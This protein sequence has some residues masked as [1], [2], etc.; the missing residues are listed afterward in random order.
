MQ[1]T[2]RVTQLESQTTQSYNDHASGRGRSEAADPYLVLA[3]NS[4]QPLS[5]SCRVSIGDVHEVVLERGSE[6]SLRYEVESQHR[7]LVITLPDTWMSGTHARLVRGHGWWVLE[8][9]CSKNGTRI[10]GGEV[11]RM[12]LSDGDLIEVGGTFLLFYGTTPRLVSEPAV[13]DTQELDDLPP[14]LATLNLPL[15]RQLA[16]LQR[17]AIANVP[18]VIVGESGTGKEVTAR[19]VHELSGRTG[20]L[21]AINCGAIPEQ[22]VES[23]LFGHRKGAFSGAIEDR[24]GLIRSAAGGTLFLDEV[25]ELPDASQAALL[26][27]LQ[28]GEVRPVGDSEVHTVDAR[29]VCATHQN[30]GERV[31]RGLFRRDLYARLAGYRVDLSPLRERRQDLGALIATLLSNISEV[32]AAAVRFRPSAARALFH[33]AFPMNI[34][35]LDHALRAA[36]LVADG[37]PIAREHLPETIV[38]SNSSSRGPRPMSPHERALRDRVVELLRDHGGNVSAVAR[39]MNKAPVQIRR[40]CKRFDINLGQFRC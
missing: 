5:P 16:G 6:R 12:P 10:N 1:W 35:E 8:D 19:A 37:E 39:E 34:R 18:I 23:E 17:V 25:A 2:D 28:E 31:N 24:P 9:C 27:F 20:P 33:H 26:R 40:W 21:V 36:I 22:L 3:M 11:Q 38:R 29:I 30:L 7:R 14:A 15:A 4:Q 32:D 13:L